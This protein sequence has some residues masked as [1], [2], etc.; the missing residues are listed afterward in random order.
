VYWDSDFFALGLLARGD[1]WSLLPDYVLRSRDDVTPFAH[2]KDWQAP[3]TI[4]LLWNRRKSV[5]QLKGAV[6]ALL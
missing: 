2:P 3:Y 4:A 5:G 6:L 1:C